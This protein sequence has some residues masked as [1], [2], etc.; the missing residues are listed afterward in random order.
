MNLYVLRQ[1]KNNG[2]DTYDSAVVVAN[3]EEEARNVIPGGFW[4]N[5][6]TLGCGT[7]LEWCSPLLTDRC[8][9]SSEFVTVTLIGPSSSG[10]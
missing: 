6:S 7:P 5:H 9:A 10:I 1:D 8:W 4:L 3:S 2:Y